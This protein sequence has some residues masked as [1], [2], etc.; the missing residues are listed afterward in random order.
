MLALSLPLNFG[1]D[2]SGCLFLYDSAVEQVISTTDLYHAVIGMGPN[3]CTEG[4]TYIT[5]LSGAITST[6]NNGGVLRV[7]DATH[8]L[9]TGNFVTLVGMGDALHNGVTA[10]TVI[11]PNTFDCD[12]IVY[13]SDA[14]TGIW[15][16]GDGIVIDAKHDNR[17]GIDWSASFTSDGNLKNYQL[18]CF[19]NTTELNEFVGERKVGTGGDLGNA[20]A[21]GIVDLVAGDVLWFA[22][23]CTNDTTTATIKHC[24]VHLHR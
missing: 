22:I 4:V 2:T 11:D 6:A 15:H 9:D 16:R 18:E 12:D 23:K 17:V 10:V 8:G 7:T 13:N 1:Y 20:S 19:Q 24:N 14:D 5:S 3:S 21:G